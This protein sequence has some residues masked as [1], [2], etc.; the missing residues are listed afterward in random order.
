MKSSIVPSSRATLGTSILFLQKAARLLPSAW[1][2]H[3]CSCLWLNQRFVFTVVHF[4]D[5]LVVH[6]VRILRGLL[7]MFKSQY[8]WNKRCFREQIGTAMLENNY[9]FMVLKDVFILAASLRT[10]SMKRKPEIGTKKKGFLA[11]SLRWQTFE[12]NAQFEAGADESAPVRSYLL[13]VSYASTYIFRSG[14]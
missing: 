14:R 5:L 11:R 2:T 13:D 10:N 4:S 8:V 6:F 1:G 7:S 3:D 9:W 12:T